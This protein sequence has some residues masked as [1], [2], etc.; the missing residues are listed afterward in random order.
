MTKFMVR[1]KKKAIQELPNNKSGV[2]IIKNH[3]GTNMYAG[4]ATRAKVQ[5]Q[6]ETH[7]H[8][9]EHYIPGAWI[10]FHQCQNITEANA[11]LD[12]ILAHQTPT[13]Q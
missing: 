12:K 2:Y 9:G 11:L 10:E 1:C 4:V 5:Q 3:N 6:L 8:D 7:F 13:Y